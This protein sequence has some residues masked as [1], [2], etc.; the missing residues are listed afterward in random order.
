MLL[1]MNTWLDRDRLRRWSEIQLIPASRYR[2]RYHFK[3]REALERFDDAIR[4]AF[5]PYGVE[6]AYTGT[7]LIG[8]VFR[9]PTAVEDMFNH[10]SRPIRNL[11]VQAD[12]ASLELNNKHMGRYLL[13]AG[14]T[15]GEHVLRYA[16]MLQAIA[17]DH[18]EPVPWWQRFRAVPVVRDV[19]EKEHRENTLKWRLT[20]FGF[21][22][23]LV[24]GALVSLLVHVLFPASQH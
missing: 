3:T 14:S 6:H 19:P 4:K 10:T 7:D 18:I 12:A 20:L 5:E 13:V 9:G 24:S 8:G 16:Q 23:G 11:R 1:R 15:S 2:G 22:G 21:A 17:K